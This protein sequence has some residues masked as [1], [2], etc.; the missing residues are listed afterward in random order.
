MTIYCKIT[1]DTAYDRILNSQHQARNLI[2]SRTL[3]A[4]AV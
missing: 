2:V 3:C 1:A 4:W